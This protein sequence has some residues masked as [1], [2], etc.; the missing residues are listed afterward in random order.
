MS[1]DLPPDLPR[2]RVIE[3]AAVL[4]LDRVR[5]K[6]HELERQQAAS[7]RPVPR[8]DT[9]YRMQRGVDEHRAPMKLHL[10]G[11][12]LGKN[13]IPIGEPE[14]RQALLEQVTACGICRPDTEL[15]M[16]DYM[17]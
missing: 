4:Y 2:L 5:R 16:L 9:R 1:D 14:A 12:A 6:I 15:G 7:G 10:A 11:C 13:G 3:T 8:P 17:G